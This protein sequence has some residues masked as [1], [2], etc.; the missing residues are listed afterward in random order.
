MSDPVE[1]LDNSLVVDWVR[2]PVSQF[3]AKNIGEEIR[4]AVLNL[5][6][7]ARTSKDP[8]VRAAMAYLGQLRQTYSLLTT[9]PK[10]ETEE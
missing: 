7:R 3:M 6:G 5:E 9:E 4:K 2:H 10:E 8:E 1:V